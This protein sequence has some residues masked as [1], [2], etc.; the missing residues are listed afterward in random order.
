VRSGTQAAPQ[1]R[2]PRP[3]GPILGRR[4]FLRLALLALAGSGAGSGAAAA[5]ARFGEPSQ[6]SV[7]RV[8]VPIPGLPSG[9]E[10]LRV[11]LLSD[12]HLHPFTTIEQVRRAAEIANGL[13]PD[14]VALL[15]DYVLV[16]AESVFDLAPLLAVLDAPLGVFTVLGNHDH[17]TNAAVVRQGL[18]EVG[19]A[20]LH[21][22]GLTLSRGA[23]RLYLC[24]L[25]DLWS[26]EPDLA[27]ALAHCPAGVPAVLLAHEPDPADAHAADPRLALQLSGH[28][29]G[30]QV[31]LPGRGALILPYLGRKYDMGLNRAGSLW[32][33]TTRGVGVIGPPFRFN[34]PPEVTQLTLVRAAAG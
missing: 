6:L 28:S 15:G 23:D 34:C 10:G 11:V 31:R 9:L 17:W 5:Y 33:Y 13:Q 27:G 25:D 16:N 14:V 7:E 18:A 2:I 4:R 8:Q 19:L 29:H 3:A 30:G 1:G 22:R 21:N 24:G 12:F 26:G 32:V 20:P